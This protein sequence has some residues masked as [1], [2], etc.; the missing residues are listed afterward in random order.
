MNMFQPEKILLPSNG[1]SRALFFAGKGGVGKTTVSSVVALRLAECGYR[2]LLVTT[3][4]AAHIG[5]VFE[6][7]VTDQIQPVMGVDNLFA[8]RIDAKKATEEYKQSI[9]EDARPRYSADMLAALAEELESPCTEEMAAFDKFSQFLTDESFKVTVFDTAPTGHT[10]RLLQLPFDYSQQV[11]LMVATNQESVGLKEKTKVRFEA[12]IAKLRDPARTTFAFVVY[13]EST[14]VIEAYRAK[15]DLEKAGITTQF[16]VANQV[17][18]VERCSH[19]FFKKRSMMQ[20]KHLA[21]IEEKFAVPI[22]QMPLF[23]QEVI[24]LQRLRQAAESVL[25]DCCIVESET[26]R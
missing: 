13:P 11:G 7:S 20:R 18:P 3:D 16:I 8:V 5:E 17:L 26:G 4:P 9:L 21:E 25:G 2:T 15:L 19:P 22:L 23:E 24:G 6:Q 12:M 14:P 1:Y 10:L